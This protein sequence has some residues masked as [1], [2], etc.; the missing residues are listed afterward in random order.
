MAKR[1]IRAGIISAIAT[2]VMAVFF[3]TLTWAPNHVY[4]SDLSYRTLDYDVTADT[5]GD[6]TVTQHIDVKMLERTD[7]DDNVKPWKQLYQQY[8][9][10][11]GNLTDITD[12]SVTNVTDGINYAQQTEPKYPDDVSDSEWDSDYANR[13]YIA[14]VTAGASQPKPY[15]PGKDGLAVSDGTGT[16]DTS[17]IIEIGWN[18]PATRKADSMKFDVTFIMH[19]V[20]TQWNDVADFQ[21]EPFGKSNPVPIGTVTGTVHFPEGI[22]KNDSWAWLHTERTSETSRTA[23]GGLKFTAYNIHSGDYLDVVAA[24]ASTPTSTGISRVRKTD[25]LDALKRSEAEQERQWQEGQ[26][27][28][29]RARLALWIATVVIGVA[30]C[31]WGLYASITSNKRSK[32]RGPIEYWRDQPG[33]S[34]A[35]AARL[36]DVVDKTGGTQSNREL[37]ATLLSLAV[38]KALAIYPGSSD[39]YRGI[40]MSRATPVE[41]SHMIAADPGR[42]R[43]ALSTSTIVLLPAAIDAVPNREQLGLSDS[44]DALLNLLTVISHRVGCPVFDFNQMRLAC[45][46]WEDGYIELGKFTTACDI[47]YVR[48]DASRSRGWQWILAGVLAAVVGFGAMIANLVIGYGMVGLITGLPVFAVGLFCSMSGAMHELTATGQEIAGRCL[49]LKR[50]MQDFSNFTDRGA[51]DLAMWDWYMVYAAAF[52]ISER[53]MRELAKAYPQVSD[54]DWLDSNAS[55]SMVYW[56]YRSHTWHDRYDYGHESGG[57]GGPWGPG[58]PGNGGGL[59]GQFGATPLFGGAAYAPG[60]SDLGSQLSS[61]F[62]DITSTIHAAAPSYDSGDSGGF[63]GSGGSFSGGGF[64]GSSGGSGGGSFGGR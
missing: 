2:L 62:A 48:L 6:L 60:F 12:I 10:R 35:S 26:R 51:A 31:A 4:E 61:G 9:L 56:T 20:M 8:T 39:L 58:G 7:S 34:P 49:G 47:E 52:G 24:Y 36:I 42:Q 17:K 57:P 11:G 27:T 38:K 54:P 25:R 40:D 21:W 22:T 14:D 59:A 18:I 37:T 15:T 63:G 55:D 41:L 23:D 29:A 64:G 33:I 13:W 53:V 44:E 32:Y 28:A 16:G 1:F 5:S 30:L 50:Y 45:R 46:D 3:V 19:D 43:A